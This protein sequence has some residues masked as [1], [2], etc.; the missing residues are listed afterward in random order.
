M[1]KV[2]SVV[3]ARPN[4]IKIAPIHKAFKNYSQSIRHLVCHTGQHFDK[5]MSDVFFNELEL[6]VPDFNLNVGSGSH[7]EQTARIMTAFEKVLLEERPD[8]IIVPG[9]VNSTMACSLVAAKMGIKIAHVES[10]LRS[11]DRSMPEEINR[12]VTDTLSDLLFVSEPSGLKN[13]ENEGIAHEKVYFT[14]N[15]MI[16][17][18]VQY[19]PKIDQSE[20]CSKLGLNYGQY[21]LVTFHRP[22]NVDHLEGL[23][24]L[25][26]YMNEWS[27]Y[28]KII[29]PVHPRTM[30]QLTEFNLIGTFS[31]NILLTEPIGYIDFLALVK[32]SFMVITDSGGIQEETTFLSIPCITVRDNTERPV[33]VEIGTNFLAGTNLIDVT[34]NFHM[35]LSGKTK[36]GRIPELWDGKAAERIVN[37]IVTNLR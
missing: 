33:T 19:M 28:K 29:F 12:I 35:I 25:V 26:K 7:A 27:N 2:L 1:K 24:S 30:R 4:F 34:E 15:V 8:L 17:S 21:I 22:A 36:K 14:G 20:C 13:L 10:G 16:D 3:G 23:T 37:I 18:L 32:H 5:K 6:P 31:K 11:F 9:D